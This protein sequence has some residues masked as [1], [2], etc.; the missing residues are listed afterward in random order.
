MH[1]RGI[2]IFVIT[3][4]FYVFS[5]NGQTVK[6]SS[7]YAIP[8]HWPAGFEKC[9]IQAYD[10]LEGQNL[11]KLEYKEYISLS[12]RG[13]ADIA[14]DTQSDILFTSYEGQYFLELTDART[15]TSEGTVTVPGMTSGSLAGVV[16]D[17]IDPNTTHLYT[18]NRG[19]NRLYCYDWDAVDKELTLITPD[20]NVGDSWHVLLPSDPNLVSYVY[21]CGLAIDSE[22]GIL[23]VSQFS[24]SG[25]QLNYSQYVHAFDRNNNWEPLRTI[26]L[27]D[28][29][30]AVDIDGDWQNGLLQY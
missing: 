10:I 14:Y 5:F 23:Y 16:L 30:E 21:G 4:C 12:A 1:I 26:D 25:Y 7:V 27:G 17:Q 15:L 2:V 20:P 8:E 24:G 19:T 29:N 28:G 22:A 6:G 11:G 13:A 3:V 9:K 18:M